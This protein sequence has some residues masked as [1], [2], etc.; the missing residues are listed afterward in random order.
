MECAC[1][2]FR[3]HS[4]ATRCDYRREFMFLNRGPDNATDWVGK[5]HTQNNLFYARL[6]NKSPEC[7]FGKQRSAPRR[8]DATPGGKDS[9]SRRTANRGNARARS[10]SPARGAP[11]RGGG[12]HSPR[13]NTPTRRRIRQVCFSRSDPDERCD[14]TDCKFSHDCAAC[15]GN[16]EARKCPQWDQK[17]LRRRN[18]RSNQ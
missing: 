3:A 14:F 9:S 11:R 7:Y 1:T 17:F 10:R 8:G 12:N 18:H 16:H 2:T 15:G 13:Q 6:I 4:K 5:F